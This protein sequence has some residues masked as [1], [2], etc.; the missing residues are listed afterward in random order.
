MLLTAQRVVSPATGVHGVNVYL[1]AHGPY[2]WP[3]V[4]DAFL[5]EVDPGELVQQWLQIDPGGNDVVSYLDVVA[6]DE[7]QHVD[8]HQRLASLKFRLQA[9][10]F[11][12]MYWDPYWIRFGTGLERIPP[13]TELG[14]LAGQIL[15]RLTG[16]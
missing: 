15:L 14:A 16:H 13:Q 11:S 1:F 12:Q 7:V 8:L 4:P 2:T 9:A 3:H 6:P 10:G 5:P